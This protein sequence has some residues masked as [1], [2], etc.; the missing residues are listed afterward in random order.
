MFSAGAVDIESNILV[1]EG[2]ASGCEVLTVKKKKI[3]Y[4][5]SNDSVNSSYC[6]SLQIQRVCISENL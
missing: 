3:R 2:E 6:I 1:L 5:E 4:P